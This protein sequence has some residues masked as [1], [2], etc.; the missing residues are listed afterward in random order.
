MVLYAGEMLHG[1]AVLI[2]SVGGMVGSL[3]LDNRSLFLNY[4]VVA[5][6]YSAVFLQHLEQWMEALIGHSER[7]MA[8]AGK[9]REALEN[10]MKVL[11]PLV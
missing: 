7:G 4:E 9:L 5:F 11:A 1:K 10:V 2:D 6:V 3:N 8:P